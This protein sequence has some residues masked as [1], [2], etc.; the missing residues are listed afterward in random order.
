MKIIFLDFDGVLNS[1]KFL[2]TNQ[3]KGF[4][5][6]QIDPQ[7]VVLLDQLVQATGAKIVISSS[8]RHIWSTWEIKQMLFKAGSKVASKAIIDR[9]PMG[10]SNR[11]Q[12]IQEWLDLDPEREVVNPEHEGVESFVI[13]DDTDDM[14]PDQMDRFVHTSGQIGLT[15]ENVSDAISI[16]RMTQ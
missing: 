2:K 14:L 1:E 6:A 16:L 9:T 5:A 11:G 7:A 3:G 15:A 13:L 8:W 10:E 12:E 4:G